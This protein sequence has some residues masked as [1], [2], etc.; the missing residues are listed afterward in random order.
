MARK[1]N[2]QGQQVRSQKRESAAGT[3]AGAWILIALVS[4]APFVW[5]YANNLHEPIRAS[6][7]SRY[8][9]GTTVV[10]WLVFLVL[11]L[12]SKLSPARL[13]AGVATAIFLFFSYYSFL[14]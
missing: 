14:T 11:R 9:I 3:G 4:L 13:G 12:V 1:P 10:A 7:V 5:F 6:D 2:S 8:A